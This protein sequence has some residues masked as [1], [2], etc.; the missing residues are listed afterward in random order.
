MW[1]YRLWFL[2]CIDLKMF[3]ILTILVQNR[4]CFTQWFG[5]RYFV[6]KELFFCLNTGKIV[7]RLEFYEF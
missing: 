6:G 2:R 4:V 5:I 1:P 7:A 3:E